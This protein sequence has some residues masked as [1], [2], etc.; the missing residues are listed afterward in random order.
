MREMFES[1]LKQDYEEQGVEVMFLHV[2]QGHALLRGMPPL[3]RRISGAERFVF[4]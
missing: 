1:D 4:L 3:P 2:T